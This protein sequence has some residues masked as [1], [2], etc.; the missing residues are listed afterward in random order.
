[1]ALSLPTG[2][3]DEASASS[4]DRTLS[5][6][7][8]RKMFREVSSPI[9]RGA[10]PVSFQAVQGSHGLDTRKKLAG[11]MP[12]PLAPAA[13]PRTSATLHASSGL[14][15]DSGDV[16]PFLEP[17]QTIMSIPQDNA[18]APILAQAEPFLRQIYPVL[19]ASV[20]GAVQLKR[21]LLPYYVDGETFEIFTSLAFL[22]F[23][24]RFSMTIACYQ[25]FKSSGS[26][27]MAKSWE[28][29]V[30][31]FRELK[32]QVEQDPEARV[33]LDPDGLGTG[34]LGP[35]QVLLCIKEV[36]EAKTEDG[37]RD[38]RRR[39]Q[40]LMRCV[41]PVKMIDAGRGLWTGLMAV[42]ATLRVRFVFTASLG[43]R[44]GKRFSDGVLVLAEPTLLQMYPEK[45][46]LISVCFR[47]ASCGTGVILGL[48][49]GRI[50]Y[51]L[52]SAHRGATHLVR[53]LSRTADRKNWAVQP[54]ALP[55]EQK[56]ALIWGIAMLGFTWQIKNG[57]QLPWLVRVPLLPAILVEQS[58]QIAATY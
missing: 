43:F 41:D 24:G 29:M 52:D 13:N 42:I 37:K 22:L 11:P 58:L 44:V 14:M 7:S 34:T 28:E 21:L 53:T 4:R 38:A 3:L 15:G 50:F 10:A 46:K 17:L 55:E 33:I 20:N 31:R 19:K 56:R 6:E 16:S 9:N 2:A 57:N 12:M 49:L 30:D 5:D 36:A 39:V 1:M 45:L 40:L 47:A 23:G 32:R 18:I 26:R 48:S 8:P 51:M 54:S 27:L 25:A 35:E